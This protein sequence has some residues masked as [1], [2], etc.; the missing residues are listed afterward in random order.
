MD[1]VRVHAIP[2]TP[3]RMCANDRVDRLNR[4]SN[5]AFPM[6][7]YLGLLMARVRSFKTVERLS[8]ARREGVV[9]CYS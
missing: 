2:R 3:Y 6:V 1:A 8:V 5:I 4:L 7:C 9:G